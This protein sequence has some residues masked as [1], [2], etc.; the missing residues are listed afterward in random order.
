MHGDECRYN[1]HRY[2][3]HRDRYTCRIDSLD[4]DDLSEILTILEKLD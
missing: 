2:D 3:G 1:G 4:T